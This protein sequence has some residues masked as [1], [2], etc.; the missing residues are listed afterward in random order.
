MGFRM[1]EAIKIKEITDV[2]E[3]YEGYDFIF[4]DRDLQ[5][6]RYFRRE[7]RR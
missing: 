5:K 4:S 2:D 3:I 6:Q 7:K 1:K